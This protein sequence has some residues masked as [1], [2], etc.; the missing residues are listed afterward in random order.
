MDDGLHRAAEGGH[1]TE[2]KTR[3]PGAAEELGTVISTMDSPSPSALSFVVTNGKAH[4]GEFVEM[5]YE[6]GTL[7]ALITNVVKTNRYFERADSV[8]EF[9]SN[10]RKMFEHFPTSEW[11]YLVAQTRPLGAYSEGRVT[12]ASF[13]PSPGTK[14]RIASAESLR[15]FLHFDD[16]G[17][18]MGEI[19][20][21]RVDVKLN[22]TKLL[23]KHLSI[24]A[25]SGAGKSY[26]VSC[27]LE[28]LL[29]RRK[30]HGRVAVVVLDPHGEYS[31]FAEPCTDKGHT[32]YS[33]RTRLVRARDIKIG[34]PKL[35]AG[36]IAGM[37]PDITS[38]QKR[39]LEKALN[40]LR[41]KMKSGEGPFDFGDVKR[42]LNRD[43]ELKDNVRAPLV[44]RLSSLEDLRIF[45]RTD[46]PSLTDLVKP[47]MLTI[48]D[49]GDLTDL[50]KKQ[51]IVS[52]FAQ[53]LFRERRAKTVPPFLLVIEEA[54]QFAP[55]KVR[56]EGA[57]SKSIIRTIAREGR[58]FGAALCLVSQRPVH[59]DTT[60][61]SQCNTHL[62]LRV[63]NPYDL[64]HIGKSSEGIDRASQDMITSLRVGEALLVGEAVNN[65]I[66]FR[67]RKRRSAPSKH[68]VPLEETARLYEENREQAKEEA[69]EFL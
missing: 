54:H 15:N 50:I 10:G 34:V 44:A 2:P 36:I 41:A 12:R 28:E 19:E 51:I 13:P 64:D 24:L 37:T 62:I 5:D 16:K 7:I 29:D 17:L 59:L 9:E 61:L 55:E 21:P 31:C 20:H 8:K 46:N 53:K 43:E 47:G 45:G 38:I 1:T 42:E 3:E 33:S 35:T 49:L 39:H 30:E 14:V 56:H 67:V 6:E 11:E 58:K 52:Y 68:E 69:E 66:F 23:Q 32:D 60:V 25:Q 22:L 4:R 57:I 27:L 65:P 63:T 26:T 18:H 40:A 48:I